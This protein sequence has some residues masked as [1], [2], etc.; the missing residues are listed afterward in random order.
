MKLQKKYGLLTAITMVVGIV[1]GSGVFFKAQTILQETE[2][3]VFTGILAW[4]IGG[5]NMLVCAIA[6]SIL[7]TKYGKINGLVDYAEETVGKKYSDIFGWFLAFIYFPAMASVLVW[8]TARYAGVLFGWELNSANVMVLSIFFF[9]LSFVT[10]A[11]APKI[12]GKVQVSTTVIKLIPLGLMMIVGVIYGLINTDVLFEIDPITGQVVN[13]SKNNMQIL[14]DNFKVE[15]NSSFT[16]LLAAIVSASF[17]YEGWVVAT[18]INGEL[19]NAKRN[20][21]I[22]LV[23]GCFIIILIYVFYFVGVLGGATSDVLMNGGTH[24]AFLQIFGNHFGTILN[25]F[26]VVS[27]FGTLNGLMLACTRSFYTLAE[28]GVGLKPKLFNQIDEQTNMPANSAIASVL[29]IAIWLVFF[30]ATNLTEGWFGAFK[31]DSSEL[32][33]VTI[34][35][36]YI[37]IFIMMIVKERKSLGV[38][39]GVV[40]P[41]LA[42]ISS[43]FMVYAAIMTHKTTVVYYLITFIVIMAM[44]ILVL[45]FNYKNKNI[46]EKGNKSSAQ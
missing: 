28:R 10:N 38:L 24:Y 45:Y 15:G 43:L 14:I 39:K 9:L 17:A 34:Y 42:I 32:P 37:P 5:I 16:A 25:V 1:I 8:V 31:F 22:A 18:S 40:C 29:V 2:G 12:A 30:Y 11:L 3:N 41:V 6:F 19:K 46:S 35:A 4:I 44:G 27:C 26:V 7:A 23:L 21:P 33:L 20:L 36:M 13:A